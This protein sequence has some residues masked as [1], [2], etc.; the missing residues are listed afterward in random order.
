MLVCVADDDAASLAILSSRAHLAW[1]AAS[2]GVLEDRPRY[3]KSRCFDPFPFPPRDEAVRTRLRETGE[4]L[5]AHRKQVL[6]D[7]PDLTLTGLYNVLELI[8]A[9]APVDTKAEAIKQRGLVVILRD[10]H[11]RIDALTAQAYG[12]PD[13]LPAAE[14]VARLA[15]LNQERA[16]EEA[17]GRI[18]WLRPAYQQPRAGLVPTRTGDLTLV[19]GVGS[20]PSRRPRFPT[21][22]YEQPLAIQAALLAAATPIA[23][24]DLARR[25][26]GGGARLEPR[27][28]RVL[29]TLHRY[30]H[31]E[32]LPDGRWIA[33][34]RAA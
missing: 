24:P 26:H 6:A 20:G 1:C 31:V 12:W 27:I 19:P 18:R 21:E 23:P 15:A 32:R 5:D 16:R 9:G 2:G 13:D 14:T 30:G 10:L 11:D 7:H 25:F 17:A 29:A 8:R 3:T 4:A 33:A 28:S 34:R 22:R